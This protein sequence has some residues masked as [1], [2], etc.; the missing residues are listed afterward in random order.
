MPL[1]S[2]ALRFGS[3]TM[4]PTLWVFFGAQGALVLVAIRL[5]LMPIA[6]ARRGRHLIVASALAVPATF[7]ISAA[8]YLFG[9]LQSFESISDTDVLPADKAAVLASGISTTMD[10]MWLWIPFA[11]ILVALLMAQVARHREAV[12]SRHLR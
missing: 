10:V 6:T 9:M 7:V 1:A 4:T 12:Q 3:L 5:C 2:S 11:V 8:S